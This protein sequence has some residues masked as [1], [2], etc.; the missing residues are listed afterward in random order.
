MSY[1]NLFNAVD[2]V[3]GYMLAK[4]K[5]QVMK[6]RYHNRYECSTG[7]L[8][9]QITSKTENEYVTHSYSDIRW[10][11]KL[12][13]SNPRSQQVQSKAKNQVE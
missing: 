8:L 3:D 1:H 5:L 11:E 13:Y 12:K 7:Y 2:F 9:S 6:L 4:M 10:Q